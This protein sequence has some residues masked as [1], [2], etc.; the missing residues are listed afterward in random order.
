MEKLWKTPDKRMSLIGMEDAKA[1]E[2]HM[3]NSPE[4]VSDDLLL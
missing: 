1:K 3:M 4:K 2:C